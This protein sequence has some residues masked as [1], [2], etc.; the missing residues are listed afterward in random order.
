MGEPQ[1]CAKAL[2]ELDGAKLSADDVEVL[3][4]Y[5]V[6]EEHEFEILKFL[7]EK[8]PTVPM[9]IPEKYMWVFGQVKRAKEKLKLWHFT[10]VVV[11]E[12]EINRSKIS[13]FDA[14]CEAVMNSKSLKSIFG[15]ILAIGNY[16]N[17]GTGR[18]RYDGFHVSLTLEQLGNCKETK[19]GKGQFTLTRFILQHFFE[20]ESQTWNDLVDDLTPLLLNV[21]RRIKQVEGADVLNRNNRVD[22]ADFES[23]VSFIQKNCQMQKSTLDTIIK[24]TTDAK[25]AFKQTMPALFQKAETMV[26]DLAKLRDK[27]KADYQTMLK[28]LHMEKSMKADDFCLMWDQFL[29]PEHRLLGFDPAQRGKFVIPKF[30]ADKVFYPDDLAILW[31]FKELPIPTK[32]DKDGGGD[33][34][35]KKKDKKHK[36]K[37]SDADDEDDPKEIA[38]KRQSTKKSKPAGERKKKKKKKKKKKIPWL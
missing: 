1:E 32:K 8:H 18:G 26:E 25:D 33:D 36:F 7:K 37:K 10:R 11:E 4:Q 29:V 9:G 30:C 15:F 38:M 13:D 31:G 2:S 6:P 17:G 22:I 24:E 20:K 5:A 14:M 28:S 23:K 27:T 35:K 34:G 3:M 21:S 16:M 12:V 19:S